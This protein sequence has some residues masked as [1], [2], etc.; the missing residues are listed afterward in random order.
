MKSPTDCVMVVH[1]QVRAGEHLAL[2][3]A[4]IIEAFRKAS[5]GQQLALLDQAIA[6]LDDAVHQWKAAN[7]QINS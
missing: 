4:A 7:R 2:T 1:D 6:R 3:A 5:N